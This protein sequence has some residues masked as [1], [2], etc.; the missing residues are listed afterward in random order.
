VKPRHRTLSEVYTL[1]SDS[2]RTLEQRGIEPPRPLI[3]ACRHLAEHNLRN[4]A[5][6]RARLAQLRKMTVID[7]GRIR[8]LKPGLPQ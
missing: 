4:I 3:L 5:R 6:S 1:L 2:I 8:P 7:G